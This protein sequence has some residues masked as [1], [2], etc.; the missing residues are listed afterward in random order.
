MRT[1]SQ[2]N[3]IER[4]CR[5][6]LVRFG[7]PMVDGAAKLAAYRCQKCGFVSIAKVGNASLDDGPIKNEQKKQK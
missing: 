2:L 3:E 4:N 7:F 1:F 5:H 6:Q